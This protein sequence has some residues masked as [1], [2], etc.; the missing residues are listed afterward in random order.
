V[1]EEAKAG[2]AVGGA[3]CKNVGEDVGM[4]EG[5]RESV[6]GIVGW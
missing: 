1:V 4:L 6:G 2:T 5:S 3:E